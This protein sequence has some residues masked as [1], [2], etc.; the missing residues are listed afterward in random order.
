MSGSARTYA[1]RMRDIDVIE[2][3]A[4]IS[5]ARVAGGAGCLTG[6]IPST[7]LIDKLLDERTAVHRT[8]VQQHTPVPSRETAIIALRQGGG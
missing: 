4:P 6:R 2:R 8:G 7:E 5:D 1:P 3:R